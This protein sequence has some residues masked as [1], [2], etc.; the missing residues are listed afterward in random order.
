M[1]F[2]PGKGS[3]NGYGNYANP[4]APK[5]PSPQN[6]KKGPGLAIFIAAGILIL[7]FVF[8]GII[9]MSK[10]KTPIPPNSGGSVVDDSKYVEVEI[11]DINKSES[12][13]SATQ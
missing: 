10:N 12:S 13:D 6:S 7:G 3:S 1:P 11:F 5:P 2:D 8:G 4:Y 9:F